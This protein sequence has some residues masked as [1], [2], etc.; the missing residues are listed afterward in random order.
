MFL[1]HFEIIDDPGQT[2]L[3]LTLTMNMIMNSFSGP[4]ARQREREKESAKEIIFNLKQTFD[5]WRNLAD[6]CDYCSFL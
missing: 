4:P 2:F 1:C 5:S 3:R 6:Y